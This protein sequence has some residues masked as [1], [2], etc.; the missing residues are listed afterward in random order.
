MMMLI[1]IMIIIIIIIVIIIQEPI[2]DKAR[3]LVNITGSAAFAQGRGII[4]T[5][6]RNTTTNII[7]VIII[8]ICFIS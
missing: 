8:V 6:I 4:I 1:M 7:I 5:G 2:C 3:D